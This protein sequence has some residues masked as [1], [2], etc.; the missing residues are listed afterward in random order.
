MN[1]LYSGSLVS[2][3]IFKVERM[4]KNMAYW[5]TNKRDNTI[6]K[7]GDYISHRNGTV[8]RFISMNHDNTRVKVQCGDG[9]FDVS[10]DEVNCVWKWHDNKSELIAAQHAPERTRSVIDITQAYLDKRFTK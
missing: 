3:R 4:V 6:V 5:L 7:T 10:P 8:M 9:R 2:P 1:A